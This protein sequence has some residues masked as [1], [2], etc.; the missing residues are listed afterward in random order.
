MAALPNKRESSIF[1]NMKVQPSPYSKDKLEHLVQSCLVVAKQQGATS[2][3]ASVN[4][5]HG[6]SVTAR[7]GEAETLEHHNDRGLGI[8]I[9]MGQKK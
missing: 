3:E 9:Y 6:L 4:V 8:T 7:L 5:E 2:A 1:I